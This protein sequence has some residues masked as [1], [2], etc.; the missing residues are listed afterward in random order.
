[1]ETAA[2]VPPVQ[3]VKI[4]GVSFTV[5]ANEHAD[6]WRR[7][8]AREWERSTF[9]IFRRFLRSDRSYMDIGAWIGPTV[10]FGAHFAQRAYA[11]EPD[12]VAYVELCKNVRLNPLMANKIHTRNI[13]I[14][15]RPGPVAF[16]NR[17]E[18]GDSTSSLLFAGARTNWVVQSKTLEDFVRDEDITDCNFIKVDIEG[19]EY[20]IISEMCDYL[21]RGFPTLH[22]SL[23]PRFIGLEH[24][25]SRFPIY[26]ERLGKTRSLLRYLRRYRFMLDEHCCPVSAEKVFYWS[27]RARKFSL[28]F[29]NVAL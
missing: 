27:V 8:E 7:V 24:K 17:G 29:T 2:S 15:S 14:S 13:C 16:G 28:V 21:L 12:P 9:D 3:T 11:I 25:G 1:M 22:L 6:F 4:E 26:R 20:L 18:A 10:L 19:G 23:H 5:C